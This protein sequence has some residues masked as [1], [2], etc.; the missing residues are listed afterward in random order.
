ML[1]LVLVLDPQPPLAAADNG[2]MFD[3]EKLD[4]YRAKQTDDARAMSAQLK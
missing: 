3:H 1:V 2:R 4:A